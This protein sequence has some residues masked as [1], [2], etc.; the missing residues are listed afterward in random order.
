[1]VPE[2]SVTARNS[3]HCGKVAAFRRE[4][5]AQSAIKRHKVP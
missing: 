3:R 1:M 5:N 4:S 2:I